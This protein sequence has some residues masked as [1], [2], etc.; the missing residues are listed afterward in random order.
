MFEQSKL[1]QLSDKDWLIELSKHLDATFIL[2][3]DRCVEDS[4]SILQEWVLGDCSLMLSTSEKVKK[5]QVSQLLGFLNPQSTINTVIKE[6]SIGVT[7]NGPDIDYV[8]SQLE[9]TVKEYI[10]QFCHEVFKVGFMGFSPGFG[11]LTGGENS[12]E[13]PRRVEPRERMRKGAV[14]I[15]SGYA[16]VYPVESPGGWNWIGETDIEVFNKAKT[17]PFLFSPLDTVTFVEI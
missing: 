8:A 9:L 2:E 15:A 10:E 4:T 5:E 12:C 3:L 7:F 13:V 17:N 11:Y 16:C 6:H 1:H 14:A